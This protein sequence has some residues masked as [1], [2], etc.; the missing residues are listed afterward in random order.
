MI[1][2]VNIFISNAHILLL[3]GVYMLEKQVDITHYDFKKYIDKGRW[4]SFYHQIDE[5]LAVQPDSVLE[6]GVGAGILGAAFKALH[7]PYESMDIDPELHP[8][9]VG[10]VLQIPFADKSYDVVGCFEVLEHL[11]YDRFGVAMRELF[12]IAKKAVVVSL[13]NSRTVWKYSIYIPKLGY[14]NFLIPRPFTKKEEA[15]FNGEH[16][17]E[18]NKKGFEFKVVKQTIKNMAEENGFA[19]EKDYSVWENPYHHFF[20]LKRL[21]YA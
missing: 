3:K 14:C 9:Y 12:R 11:P 15:V 5:I 18:I 17:W 19:L 7:Y 8:D 10:S 20:T 16:Y 2:G 6:I 1:I 13:P 4:N 21:K